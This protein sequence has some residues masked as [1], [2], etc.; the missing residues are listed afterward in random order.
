[1]QDRRHSKRRE[2]TF[3]LHA[4]DRSN[5]QLLGYVANI[6]PGGVM[7]IGGKPIEA[8][9]SVHFE[10]RLPVEVRGRR[11]VDFEATSKWSRKEGEEFF[12]SGFELGEISPEGFEIIRH[13]WSAP[14]FDETGDLTF[15]RL[16]DIVASFI[17]LVFS[18]PI[19]LLVALILRLES[20]EPILYQADRVGRF[21]R[22][23][24]KIGRAHV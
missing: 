5:E 19:L 8:N 3:Y 7:L 2:L 6:S 1:M 21:G 11:H 12:S 22:L 24:R 14:T 17:S 15:R 4:F 18:S 10:L 20:R 13:V 23:F 9:T 16:F